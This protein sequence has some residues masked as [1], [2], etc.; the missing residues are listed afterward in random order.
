LKK[1]KTNYLVSTL[2]KEVPTTIIQS[3]NNNS[4]ES[5]NNS[6]Q[7]FDPI[8]H[9]PTQPTAIN[10]CPQN[11]IVTIYIQHTNHESSSCWQSFGRLASHDFLLGLRRDHHRRRQGER[12][13]NHVS[14]LSSK[15]KRQQRTTTTTTRAAR[16]PVWFTTTGVW[17]TIRTQPIRAPAVWEQCPATIVRT[18]RTTAA[19]GGTAAAANRGTTTVLW[20]LLLP[21][22]EFKRPRLLHQQ[23]AGGSQQIR[24]ESSI[25]SWTNKW[26]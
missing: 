9:N 26:I 21:V 2:S 4:I 16:A 8:Q 3:I 25:W 15:R 12:E 20:T 22:P 23:P 18:G 1:R 10:T 7:E 19:I 5:N 24:A 11:I 6:I 14:D 13:R 17:T